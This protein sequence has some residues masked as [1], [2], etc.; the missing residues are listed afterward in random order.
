MFL[1]HLN[2][3][4]LTLFLCILAGCGL[5]TPVGGFD[6]NKPLP[7]IISDSSSVLVNHAIGA[8]VT[9]PDRKAVLEISQT[10]LNADTF[11]KISP[12]SPLSGASIISIDEM[13]SFEPAIVTTLIA[14]QN[15]LV[16]LRYD[17]KL[18]PSAIRENDL[19]LGQLDTVN[20][21]WKR[22]FLDSPSV[23]PGL[24]FHEVTT[25]DSSQVGLTQLGV[26][27]VT[28]FNTPTCPNPP[29]TF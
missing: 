17:P 15:L 14:G 25:R 20:N 24:T 6:P 7:V 11:I 3:G 19:R 26:F 23:I 18:V 16:K 28:I 9:T 8:I 21:C 5:G 2:N 27:G 13:Y 4:F 10:T 1:N 22:I 12:Y 29:I